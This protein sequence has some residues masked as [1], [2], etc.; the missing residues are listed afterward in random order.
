MKNPLT[1]SGIE[2][3]T[4]RFGAQHVMSVYYIF[5][6]AYVWEIFEVLATSWVK[7]KE[8]QDSEDISVDGS[9]I[10]RVQ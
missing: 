8:G 7:L 10:L 9:V 1:P 5:R 3:A 4:F 6:W 2:P